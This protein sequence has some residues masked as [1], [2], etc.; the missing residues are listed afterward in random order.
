[1]TKLNPDF[2]EVLVSQET[3]QRFTTEDRLRIIAIPPRR[4]SCMRGPNGPL[5]S[6]RKFR[7]L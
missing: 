4:P 6:G 5:S 2:W 7:P 3:L 1:M